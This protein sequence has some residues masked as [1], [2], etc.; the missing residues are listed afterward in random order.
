LKGLL[1]RTHKTRSR[2]DE[3]AEL[4]KGRPASPKCEILH[5]ILLELWLHVVKPILTQ[6][7]ISVRGNFP[8]P[9]RVTHY[10]ISIR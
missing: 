1:H 9:I 3:E 5:K 10:P 7:T 8:F 4:R 2:E 6:L